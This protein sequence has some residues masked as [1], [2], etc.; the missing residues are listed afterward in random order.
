M[1]HVMYRYEPKLNRHKQQQ[2]NHFYCIN[3][4]LALSEN[5]VQEDTKGTGA[6][7]FQIVH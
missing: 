6:V 5:K 1:G 7:P 3:V 4:L 2:N